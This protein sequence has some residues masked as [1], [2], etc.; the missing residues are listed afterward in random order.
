V[1][2]PI[3]CGQFLWQYLSQWIGATDEVA[4]HVTLRRLMA[5][6]DFYFGVGL[7]AAS[8]ED[9]Q[10]IR[11]TLP[12]FF[13]FFIYLRPCEVVHVLVFYSILISFFFPLLNVMNSFFLMNY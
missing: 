5:A 7:L 6:Q 4:D 12:L 10:L 2:S 8:G 9:M 13:L 11:G 3:D 1:V